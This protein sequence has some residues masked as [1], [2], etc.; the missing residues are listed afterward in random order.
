M[1]RL[2]FNDA[3]DGA[4]EMLMRSSSSL[5]RNNTTARRCRTAPAR[6]RALRDLYLAPATRVRA[7]IRLT[8]RHSHHSPSAGAS[9]ELN[10]P[11][12][13]PMLSGRESVDIVEGVGA[14]DAEAAGGQILG[15]GPREMR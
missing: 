7:T 5:C 9:T 13:M 3:E 8:C 11:S 2:G 15:T 1:R 10:S 4:E 12:F 6:H 14:A